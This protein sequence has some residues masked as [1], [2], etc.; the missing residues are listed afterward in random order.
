[1][2]KDINRMGKEVSVDAA[3]EE[4]ITETGRVVSLSTEHGLVK[5]Y[6]ISGYYS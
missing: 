4:H 2:G 1:M 5:I 6:I 3:G